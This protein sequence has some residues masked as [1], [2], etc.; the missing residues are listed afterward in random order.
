[1]ASLMPDL[2]VD[3]VCLQVQRME[4]RLGVMGKRTSLWVTGGL[5]FG[6]S[7]CGTLAPRADYRGSVARVAAEPRPL[8]AGPARLLHVNADRGTPFTLYRIPSGPDK[9]ADCR[10]G[11]RDLVVD[12][13]QGSV[14][15]GKNETICV[16][17]QGIAQVSW[18]AKPVAGDLGTQ[19]ASLDRD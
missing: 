18:H 7:G 17:A 4:M 2:P 10:G 5:A 3:T 9:P 12:L 11:R 15:V 19:Q 1:M 14:L 8:L 13:T 16:A 6:M